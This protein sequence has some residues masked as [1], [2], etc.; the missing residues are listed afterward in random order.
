MQER[1]SCGASRAICKQVDESRKGTK[2]LGETRLKSSDG[3]ELGQPGQDATLESYGKMLYVYQSEILTYRT[4]HQ[5][6][7]VE[8]PNGYYE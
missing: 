8:H 7:R 2:S 5:C 1:D 6:S 3:K 4:R